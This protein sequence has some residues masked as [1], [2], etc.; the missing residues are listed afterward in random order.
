MTACSN[1]PAT[2]KGAELQK[3]VAASE[4]LQQRLRV[5]LSQVAA[6]HGID[7]EAFTLLHGI[8]NDRGCTDEPGLAV[9]RSAGFV[10]GD[11]LNAVVTS[12][13]MQTYAAINNARNDWLDEAATKFDA[14]ALRAATDL[15]RG[16]RL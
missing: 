7:F 9:L 4:E 1:H 5:H 8:V 16:L 13:G 15:L 14:E 6:R 11:E 12:T 3:L 2:I 10:G